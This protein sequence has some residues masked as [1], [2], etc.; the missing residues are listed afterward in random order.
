MHGTPFRKGTH[1]KNKEKKK[2]V[3]THAAER[4]GSVTCDVI[5]R[6]R[7]RGAEV[8]GKLVEILQSLFRR[9]H[10]AAD[11]LVDRVPHLF[12]AE[13][14]RLRNLDSRPR[15]ETEQQQTAD[16]L[17]LRFELGWGWIGDAGG[18]KKIINISPD[19]RSQQFVGSFRA[20]SL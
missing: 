9:N 14:H 2:H 4:K 8:V 13:P 20:E 5:S 16:E 3:G 18:V 1:T 7:K 19:K 6:C 17:T 12:R 15:T 10:G 11:A